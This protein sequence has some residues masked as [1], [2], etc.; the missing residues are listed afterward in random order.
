VKSIHFKPF[1]FNEEG[2][3]SIWWWDLAGF[4]IFWYVCEFV[5]PMKNS[6]VPAWSKSCFPLSFLAHRVGGV[7]TEYA[8]MN[9]QSWWSNLPEIISDLWNPDVFPFHFSNIFNHGGEG[10]EGGRLFGSHDMVN[11]HDWNISIPIYSYLLYKQ[12]NWNELCCQ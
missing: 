6:P 1:L 2:K 5:A 4:G 11:Q 12:D 10:G 7:T 9:G 8:R 3:S